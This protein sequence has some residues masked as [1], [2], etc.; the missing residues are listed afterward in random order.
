MPES[1]DVTPTRLRRL[2]TWLLSQASARAHR[3]LSDGL[4]A[5]NARGY[6]F[7]LLAALDD[8]GPASQADLGRTLGLDRSD[9]AVGLQELERRKLVRR[10]TDPADRRRKRVALTASGRRA[11]ASLDT[12]VRE[13]QDRV[14]EPLTTA[15][16][17][18]LVALL[19][20]LQPGRDGTSHL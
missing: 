7:R 16:R 12:T 8:L 19:E 14:L 17:A 4:A 10:T 9:V 1:H 11:L 2:P 15:E 18:T 3:L 20:R 6:H 5:S 13:L